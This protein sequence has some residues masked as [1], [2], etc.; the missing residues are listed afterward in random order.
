MFAP[1]GWVRGPGT[2]RIYRVLKA[3][4]MFDAS[5]YRRYQAT[6][7]AK[8]SDPI[9]HYMDYG[10]MAGLD[11]SPMFDSSFY[12][13]Q[14]YDV[15]QSRI[16][17]LFHYLEYGIAERR[18]PMR[19]AL[20]TFTHLFPDAADLPLFTTPPIGRPRLSVVVDGH[21]P[22]DTGRGLGNI[23]TR[24]WL[25]A[26]ADHRDLRIIQS[27]SL[28]VSATE[29]I[30][31]AE[32]DPSRVEVVRI[33]RGDDTDSI[34]AVDGEV[35]V[36]TSWTS[37]AA[38]RFSGGTPAILDGSTTRSLGASGWR[39]LARTQLEDEAALV[40]D[41]PLRRLEHHGSARGELRVAI[42]GQPQL[43][44]ATVA[45]CLLEIERWIFHTHRELSGFS[46]ALCGRG[47]E[48]V[49]VAG[50]RVA[51]LLDGPAGVID[52]ALVCGVAPGIEDA[53]RAHGASVVSVPAALLAANGRDT[54][55]IY[56]AL[57]DAAARARGQRP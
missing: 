40:S 53:L 6:G 47:F 28:E 18:S 5:W 52:V 51:E 33:R 32:L 27:S 43:T 24:A 12:R 44:P 42:V 50:E 14:Y 29:A 54:S 49:R 48:P 35:F 19:S 20:Q 55:A 17:P 23:V 31:R 11:P 8:L 15:R 4:D 45:L 34:P 21:T 26:E 7:L 57:D 38:V 16:T 25:L 30:A 46:L 2:R 37:A 1:R 22:T 3:S 10:A 13:D 36:A 41:V 9:W 56:E 39:E